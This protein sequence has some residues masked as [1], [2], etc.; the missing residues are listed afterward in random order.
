MGVAVEGVGVGVVMGGVGVMEVVVVGAGVMGVAEDPCD[1]EC[2]EDKSGSFVCVIV[3]TYTV[4]MSIYCAV[5]K[6]SVASLHD[7]D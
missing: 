4:Y 6:K 1:G 7:D 5:L 3:L 2:E